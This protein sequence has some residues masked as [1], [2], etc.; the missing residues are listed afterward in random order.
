MDTQEYQCARCGN[1]CRWPGYVL[2]EPEE[3]TVLARHLAL[4][5]EDFTA[6]YTRVPA[7]RWGLSLVEKEDGSC[8]FLSEENG[9]GV[10]EVKPQQCRDFPQHW[11]FNGFEALCHATRI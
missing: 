10:Q 4:A 3:V 1:C 7:N 9:C 6:R 8:V 2:L 5:V 11:N